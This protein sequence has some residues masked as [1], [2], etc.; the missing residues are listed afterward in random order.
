MS[1]ISEKIEGNKI[2]N[3]ISSTNI[4]KTIYDTQNKTLLVTFN[5]GF[6]YEYYDVPHQIYTRF[7]LAPSQGKFFSTE[8]SKKYNNKKI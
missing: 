3:E 1:I 7:R 5:T 6:I 8:I 2:I 4:I